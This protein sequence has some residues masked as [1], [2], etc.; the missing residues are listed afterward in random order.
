MYVNFWWCKT[1][2]FNIFYMVIY[3][4]YTIQLNLFQKFFFQWIWKK[5]RIFTSTTK[6]NNTIKIFLRFTNV[7]L[8]FQRHIFDN[9]V[10]AFLS[11]LELVSHKKWIHFLDITWKI[12]Q[13]VRKRTQEDSSIGDPSSVSLR[14]YASLNGMRR[15]HLYWKRYVYF[16]REGKR[17]GKNEEDQEKIA[18]NISMGSRPCY[19]HTSGWSL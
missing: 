3:V 10:I 14:N 1:C 17:E 2:V 8:N 5:R 6:S 4:I 7:I 11:F 12:K 18:S 15:M 13:I 19:R 16:R 9:S